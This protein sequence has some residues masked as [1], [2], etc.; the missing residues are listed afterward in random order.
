MAVVLKSQSEIQIMR[1]SALINIEVLDS[2]REMVR[3]GVMARDL[4]QRAYEIISKRGGVPAF[5]GHPKGG[6]HPYPATITVC[7]N[8]EL[9]HGMPDDKVLQD[10]DLLTLDCGTIYKGYVSDSAFSIGVGRVTPEVQR[11]L[12][13]TERSLY[14]GI[15][16]C[17]AGKRLGDI[18]WA[19]QSYVEGE[20]MNVVRGYGGHG[21]G[22][23]MWED[24][25]IPNHGDPGKGI[26]LKRG[27]VFALEPM[28]MPGN[29]DT[30]VLNDHWTVVMKEDRK[31]TRLN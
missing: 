17:Q 7:I 28:V 3:P 25:H 6:K 18:G 30:V 1:E 21:V 31:S 11:L 5:L 29:P 27:M 14:M 2:L 8:E 13:V 9:V 20:G 19:I 12:D 26:Q 15:E 23:K 24:P 16:A 22:R 10:G 4:D